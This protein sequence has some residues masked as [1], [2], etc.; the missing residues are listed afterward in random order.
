[1]PYVAGRSQTQA[2]AV[3]SS[4]ARQRSGVKTQIKGQ[5]NDAEGVLT[6]TGVTAEVELSVIAQ[7]D[8]SIS[9]GLNSPC[10]AN[11]S[12]NYAGPLRAGTP[13]VLVSVENVSTAGDS[14]TAFVTRLV[15]EPE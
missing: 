9:D 11:V 12:Q 1:V 7:S 2:G 3:Q 14:A 10:F 4:I 6:L 15:I 5:W 13:I 8:V